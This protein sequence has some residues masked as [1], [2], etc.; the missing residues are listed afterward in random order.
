MA[1]ETNVLDQLIGRIEDEALRDRLAREVDLLRGSRRFGMVFDRHL[2]ESVRLPDHPIRKGIRVALRDESSAETWTVERFTDRAR[3]VAVLSG[4]GGERLASDLIVIREFGVPIYPGLRSVE[5]IARGP[6]HAPWHVVINGENFHALQALRSTH[7][8]KVD[9]IYI[10][11][12]YNTGNDGWIYND[13]YV[14]QNDRAKS[15]KWLS[16]LERRLLIAKDLLKPTGVIIV[17]IGDEEHHRLRMLLDQIFGDANF[18]SDVVWIG[19]VKNDARFN[20]G[21]LDYMLIYARNQEALVDSGAV[22]RESK[23]GLQ[24]VL[25]AG[26]KAWHDSGHDATKASTL[27]SGWWSRNKSKY[28][29]GLGDNVK[30]DAD[31]T[32]I[33]VS[34]LRSPTPRP[35]LRYDL[36][37]P[38]TGKPVRMHPN[39]W[40]YNENTMRELVEAGRVLFGEDHRSGARKTTPLAEMSLQSVRPRFTRD[41][42]AASKRLEVLLGDKRFPF[43]KD[44]EVLMRWFRLTVPDDAVIIDFF[45]GSGTTSEA[46]MQLNAEDGGTRQSILVTNNEIG[47]TEAKKLR[48][49]G[50]H[51][52]DPEWRSRGVFEYVCRPRISTVVTGTRPDGS[53]YSDGLEANVEMFDLT[54]LDPGM[55]RRGHEFESVAPLFWLEAGARGERIEEV[56]EQGWAL[57]DSYGV[58]FDFD[59]L[60]AFAAAV[61]EATTGERTPVALFIITDSPAEYQQAVKRLPVGIETVQLYEDYL[62]NYTINTVGGAR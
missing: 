57:T 21:G 11:P 28:E 59:M 22:W 6:E 14:D 27:L 40:V 26:A 20:G 44:H 12:P 43:P 13:R 51:P 4:D 33:K 47:A 24:D 42:R 39:G 52:G 49:Q 38:I 58:L 32:V 48:G 31:G 7:R 34:D 61:T 50:L 41:R 36:P 5:R 8:E 29:P 23:D 15:S 60:N 56:P 53:N 2:P 45:G 19:A 18:I 30:V 54:Y 55:V 25:D 1:N 10:D 35:N 46:V 9:L 17:A 16:F 62:S 37:H 3:E